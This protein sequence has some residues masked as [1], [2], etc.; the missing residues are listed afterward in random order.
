MAKWKKSDRPY[1]S[2]HLDADVCGARVKPTALPSSYGTDYEWSIWVGPP[3]RRVLHQSGE[4]RTRAGAK[5]IARARLATCE[6]WQRG[7]R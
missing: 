2:E 4:A 1:N 7:G 6:R 5:R 3:G